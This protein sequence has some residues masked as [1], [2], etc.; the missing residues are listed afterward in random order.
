MASKAEQA[1][2]TLVSTNKKPVILKTKDKIKIICAK[3][4]DAE[5][6]FINEANYKEVFDDKN[7]SEIIDEIELIMNPYRKE[8]M[9]SRIG[10]YDDDL[11][12]LATLNATLAQHSGAIYGLSYHAEENLK[13][14]GA[15]VYA[16]THSAAASNDMSLSI[17]ENQAI[18]RI[19]TKD[20]RERR[21][22]TVSANKVIG[23]YYYAVKQFIEVL[24][25][26]SARHQGA[27][28]ANL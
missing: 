24:T 11:V 23:N 15:S 5:I 3:L 22:A 14:T 21:V 19:M 6:D 20:Q 18:N 13:I 16:K 2:A 10:N 25:S 7:I 4:K 12:K 28:N 26:V 9:R 8:G 1:G 17:A 27:F